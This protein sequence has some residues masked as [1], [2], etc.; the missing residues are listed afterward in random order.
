M[1]CRLT[2]SEAGDVTLVTLRADLS[3]LQEQSDVA[4]YR[5]TMEQIIKG[6]YEQQTRKRSR[7]A[8]RRASV[9]ARRMS[10]GAVG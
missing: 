9:T 1:A 6:F 3:S 7:L 10:T 5:R 2:K 4:V 8:A